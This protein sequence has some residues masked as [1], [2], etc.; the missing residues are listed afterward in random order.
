MSASP[1]TPAEPST[2]EPA[3]GNVP[4]AD[5]ATA[6]RLLKWIVIISVVD[7]LL[8]LPLIYGVITGN[9]D[10]TPI[11]GPLHGAGFMLEVGLVAWGWIQRWWGLWYV[12]LTV[13]TTGPPGALIGH[14]RA[15]REALGG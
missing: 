6:E 7:L 9:K 8:L 4:A 3:A 14:G 15:K 10:L 12:A 2:P 1:T 11:F 5:R 13:V